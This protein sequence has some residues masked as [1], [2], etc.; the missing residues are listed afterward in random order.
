MGV[1]VTFSSAVKWANRFEVLEHHADPRL[2]PRARQVA[3]RSRRAAGRWVVS[4]R[5]A[6][7]QDLAVIH[8]FEMVHHA[9]QRALAGSARPE[10]YD[11][12][13]LGHA[14]IHAAEDFPI[15]VGFLHVLADDEGLPRCAGSVTPSRLRNQASSD[16]AVGS[17]M[18][19]GSAR[20]GRPGV[21]AI[22]VEMALQHGLQAR[23]GAGQ[24]QVDHP[25]RD[26]D[27]EELEILPDDLLGTE[28]SA[29]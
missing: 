16:S 14:E 18:T 2:G 6:I 3:H 5:T 20:A 8:G 24:D 27:L 26:E 7:D 19:G 28:M 23:D 15:A 12:L 22:Q 17:G 9:Q 21:H 1:S 4:H 13:A 25:G 10:D 29:R 11:D